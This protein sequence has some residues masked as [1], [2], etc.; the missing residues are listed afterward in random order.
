MMRLLKR[1]K[2]VNFGYTSGQWVRIRNIIDPLLN[3]NQAT[4]RIVCLGNLTFKKVINTEAYWKMNNQE[5]K[6]FG[7]Q[8]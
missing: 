5:D 8:L 2:N 4:S 7:I 6:K 1:N 3:A